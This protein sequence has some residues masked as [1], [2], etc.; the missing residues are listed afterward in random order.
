MQP[1]SVDFEALATTFG[2]PFYLYDLDGAR[3]RLQRL[4]EALPATIRL[5]YC[6]K[7]NP[8]PEVLRGF[9]DVVDGLD[10]SS[11]GEVRLAQ[12]VGYHPTAMSFAGPGKTDAELSEAIE[13]RV[14]VVSI[15]SVGELRRLSSISRRAGRRAGVTLRINPLEPMKHFAMRMGGQASPFG[16]PE[17]CAEA[18]IGEAL[19]DS[20]IEV[21]GLHVYA[22]TQCLDADG[23]ADGV[24]NTL[25]IAAR[26]SGATGM[27]V[28]VLNLG[29]GIGVPYFEGDESVDPVVV[30]VAIGRVVAEAATAPVLEKSDFVLE[31][32]RYL[33]GE[34]GTYV[35]KVIDVKSARGKHFAILDGGMHHCFAA[36]GNFGQLIKRNFQTANLSRPAGRTTAYDV[37]GPLCTPLDTLARN[38]ALPEL[39]PGDLVG[40]RHCGAYGL[41][42]SPVLFLG[43]DPPAEIIRL[44][45]RCALS[46][47]RGDSDDAQRSSPDARRSTGG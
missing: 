13:R 5:F 15:E 2:T 42:A 3:A 19:N 38:A 7:A 44:G 20:A 27:Q 31:L 6:P 36:T 46:H 43:H 33:I 12:R 41:S 22:G 34:F 40:I 14:G 35:A 47:H 10:V 4:R 30:S 1:S 16:I 23:I 39:A 8:N 45:G 37:V 24:R 9:H 11:I 21:L 29:G 17:E 18:V 28:R 32:G 25:R 26:L